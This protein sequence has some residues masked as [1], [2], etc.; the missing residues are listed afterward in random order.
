MSATYGPSGETSSLKIEPIDSVGTSVTPKS[1][2]IEEKLLWEIN[3]ELVPKKERGEYIMGTFLDIV[4]LPD[5]DCAG[6]QED[7]G[8][9]VI[10]RNSGEKGTRYEQFKWKRAECGASL[11]IHYLHE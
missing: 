2:I 1:P 10:Y 7:W 11:G 4:C 3:D 9:L 8:R 5:N 6:V